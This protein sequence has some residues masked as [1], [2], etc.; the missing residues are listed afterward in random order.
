[1]QRRDFVKLGSMLAVA[2][3]NVLPDDAVHSSTN[4]TTQS[5]DFIHDG[6]QLSPKEYAELLMKLA[7]EG[8]IKPDFYSNG[9]V[10][11]ELE[12]KFA[13]LLGKDAAVFMPT[14]TLANHLAVRRLAGTDKRVIVQEQKIGRAHV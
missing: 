4:K 14:G 2:P 13:R 3:G 12:H 7:D 6:L 11:E 8:R 1:M 9:G 10:V 5:T